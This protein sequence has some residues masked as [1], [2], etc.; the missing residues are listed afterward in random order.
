M[1]VVRSTLTAKGFSKPEID[2]L[3]TA[4]HKR[5]PPKG[6]DVAEYAGTMGLII[7][8]S[9]PS[10]ALIRIDHQQPDCPNHTT[11]RCWLQGGTHVITLT[12]QGFETET[13]TCEVLPME[14][15]TFHRVLRSP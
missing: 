3:E 9:E 10:G 4:A 8:E 1:E 11:S 15:T 7:I 12:K 13:A 14:R 2:S 6:I 5:T